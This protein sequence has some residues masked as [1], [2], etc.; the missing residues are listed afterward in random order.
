MWTFRDDFV[1]TGL[2]ECEFKGGEFAGEKLDDFGDG[3]GWE[4]EGVDTMDYAVCA[5]L[6]ENWLADGRWQMGWEKD[7]K[8]RTML[9]A[10]TLL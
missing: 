10:M 4:D 1:E 7:G 3:R 9:T 6:W 8:G 5:E 2:H